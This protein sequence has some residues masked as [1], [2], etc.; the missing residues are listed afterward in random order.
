MRH[1]E[2]GHEQIREGV[3]VAVGDDHVEHDRVGQDADDDEAEKDGR[4]DGV[5]PGDDLAVGDGE[6]RTARGRH[7]RR[8]GVHDCDDVG[9][10]SLLQM[11]LL[12]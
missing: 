8:N 9:K 4:E 3:H 7:R 11:Q 5:E 6:I 10:V 12:L 2:V 1:A